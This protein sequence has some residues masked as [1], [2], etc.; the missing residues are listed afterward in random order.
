MCRVPC[1][2]V[3]CV[4]GGDAELFPGAW[5]GVCWGMGRGLFPLVSTGRVKTGQ[6]SP[7]ASG[8]RTAT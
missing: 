1:A 8:W 7:E 2:Q 6:W 5:S 4:R 3:R